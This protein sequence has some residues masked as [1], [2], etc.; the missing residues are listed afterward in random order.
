[1]DSRLKALIGAAAL[2]VITVVIVLVAQGGGDDS[3]S[4]ADLEDLS[5]K[6]VIEVP[7]G[8]PPTKLVSDDIVEGDGAEAKTGDNL[9]VEYVGVDYATGEEFD[10]S[11]GK[12]PF[13]FQL[14]SGNVIPG[15]D[16]GLVGMKVGGRRELTIPPDLAYGAQGSG[17]IGP[18][19]TLIFVIDLTAI[20]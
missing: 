10:T 5:Q 16:Q 14:G 1:M 3:S 11:W 9:T 18:D 6:P 7:D 2:L 17:P 8:D 4:S 13:Q 20:G 12:E 19:A 15:W